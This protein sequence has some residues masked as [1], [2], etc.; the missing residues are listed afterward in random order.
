MRSLSIVFSSVSAFFIS[1]LLV[2]SVQT[3]LANHPVPTLTL[4]QQVQQP[5]GSWSDYSPDNVTVSPYTLVRLRW[6][7]TNVSNCSGHA[8]GDG[9]FDISGTSGT[10]YVID[11]VAYD[12]S[13][14]TVTCT[15]QYGTVSSDITVSTD[16]TEI[17]PTVTLEQKTHNEGDD[18]WSTDHTTIEPDDHIHFRW[19]SANTDSC[20]GSGFYTDGD[21]EGVNYSNMEPPVG[22]EKTY[23]ITCVGPNG[24]ASDSITVTKSA[25]SIPPFPP[26]PPS[27]NPTTPPTVTLEQKVNDGSWSS[28]NAVIDDGDQVE[29]RWTSTN[30]DSCS[31]ASFNA[32]GTSG[33]ADIDEPDPGQSYT[34]VII[35]VGPGGAVDADISVSTNITELVPT[36]TLEQ[37]F[38]HQDSSWSDYSPDNVI[39]APGTPVRLRWQGTNVSSCSGHDTDD[40]GFQISGTSGTRYF[41]IFEPDYQNTYTVT[42]T[43]QYGTVADSIS[44]VTTDHSVPYVTLEQ[45]THNEGDDAWST[46]HTIIEPDD[47]IHFR[48]SSADTDSCHGS[49][50][51]TDGDTEGV[52]YSN[53]EPSI[54]NEKTYTIN[55][56][57]PN[58]IASDSITVTKSAGSIPP[59]P[60]SP[61]PPT[62]TLEQKYKG[63]WSTE[64]VTIVAGDRVDL[65]WN[66][67]H[68]D[69]CSAT[70]GRGFST[71]GNTSGYDWFIDEPTEGN[72]E[73]FTVTCTG[74][75]GTVSDSVIITAVGLPT[76]TLES[77]INREV[78][79]MLWEE[80]IWSDSSKVGMIDGDDIDLRWSSTNTDSCQATSGSGF[81][82]GGDSS[83]VDLTIDMPN[84]NLNTYTI[85]CTGPGGTVSD[86]VLIVVK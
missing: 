46:D 84:T 16:G 15:G 64:D 5:N 20:H 41:V 47:H 17:T 74:P 53:M 79:D 48:W 21:T 37:Q 3:A 23:T 81:H 66:S 9:S 44:L 60:P 36:L 51:Y 13:I 52:N 45:K 18:A 65:K 12:S 39:V 38:Q 58:D 42:C 27:P 35:C 32:S 33:T 85:T 80:G 82:T 69:S 55:C 22:D 68:T 26:F 28:A 31:G 57:G 63:V 7:G 30:A 29:L 86:S 78:G 70:S 14:Y 10:H 61:T 77:R 56:T 71:G 11:A 40:S 8:T 50:F 4:E 34:Y 49:G 75:G 2:L 43:G 1:G 72:S 67:A 62:V 19:S 83:G 54:G 24:I 59:F 76:V 25:G 73:T 6:Q